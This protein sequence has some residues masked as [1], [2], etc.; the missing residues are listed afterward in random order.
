MRK[1]G[2]KSKSD[3]LEVSRLGAKCVVVWFPGKLLLLLICD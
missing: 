3:I 1:K 2:V